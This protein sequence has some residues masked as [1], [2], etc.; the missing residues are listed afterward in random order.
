MR[1]FAEDIKNVSINTEKEDTV[2]KEFKNQHKRY[3]SP[4]HYVAYILS[5]MGD[6]VWNKFSQKL[7]SLQ[8]SFL[9]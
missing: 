3:L 4:K 7:F 6:T 8:P 2:L 9:V 5:G 1:Y